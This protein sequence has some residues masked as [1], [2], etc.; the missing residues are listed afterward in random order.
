MMAISRYK[1]PIV[2]FTLIMI[3]ILV[4]P[5]VAMAEEV[6][7]DTGSPLERILAGLI[8]TFTTIF[9][10][11]AGLG[12]S[13]IKPLSELVFMTGL[14]GS[15]VE[16][17]PWQSSQIP[18]LKKFYNVLAVSAFPII[19]IAIVVTAYRFILVPVSPSQRAEGIEGI[20]RW[21]MAIGIIILAPYFIEFLLMCSKYLINLIEYVFTNVVGGGD[22]G[23][24]ALINPFTM[25]LKTG[26]FLGTALVKFGF[27]IIYIYFNVLYIIRMA[28]ISVMFI[29]TPLMA[30]FWAINKNVTAI[31]VWLGELASNAFMPVAHA[32]TFCVILM[33]TDI[34]NISTDGGWFM[35]LV[36]LF[37]LVPLSE[38]LRN[39]MQSIITRASGVSEEGLASKVMGGLTGGVS[40]VGMATMGV[41]GVAGAAG[42]MKGKLGAPKPQKTSEDNFQGVQKTP[43]PRQHLGIIMR[44]QTTVPR[45]LTTKSS[46]TVNKGQAMP[47]ATTRVNRQAQ[48][49]E[50][51]GS[52]YEARVYGMP[53]QAQAREVQSIPQLN[54]AANAG[55]K[56]GKGVGIATSIPLTMVGGIAPGGQQIASGI[57]KAIDTSTRIASTAGIAGG[58]LAVSAIKHRGIGKAMQEVAGT[59]NVW[60][61]AKNIGKTAMYAGVN[62]TKAGQVLGE[63]N[64]NAPKRVI[65]PMKKPPTR[66]AGNMATSETFGKYRVARMETKKVAVAPPVNKDNVNN[67]ETWE[68]E[69]WRSKGITGKQIYTLNK[70]GVGSGG[71]NR[72]EASDKIKKYSQGT[73][74]FQ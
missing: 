50:V 30:M 51:E 69:A 62:P 61:G 57:G 17:L 63:I 58:Q 45:G 5:D 56:L 38:A 3:F 25:D 34:Q 39:S 24:L 47:T 32:L 66:I 65:E 18:Y 14:S 70:M 73:T 33:L 54:Y 21:F 49:K 6:L 64:K 37:T 4:L 72:G 55:R 19:I 35:I 42:A 2:L 1:M 71:L 44:P 46:A 74:R 36:L 26:S 23:D 16:A 31:S 8:N 13:G 10:K 67:Y 12:N 53:K 20:K 60:E 28:A 9:E 11:I 52:N 22:I 43:E 15:E 48:V 29:F 27:L 40:R 7:K 59:S 41:A 68:N